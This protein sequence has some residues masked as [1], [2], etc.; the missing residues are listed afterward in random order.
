VRIQIRRSWRKP[1][2]LNAFVFQDAAKRIAE[3]RIAIHNQISLV[4]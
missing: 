2:A 4:K 1:N 3:L